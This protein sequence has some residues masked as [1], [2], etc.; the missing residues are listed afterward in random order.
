MIKIEVKSQVLDYIKR[1]WKELLI[2]ALLSFFY[3]KGK[4]DYASLYDLHLETTQTY[5]KRIEDLNK[6]HKERIKEKDEAIEQYIQRVEDLRNDYDTQ[7]EEIKTDRKE[8]QEEIEQILL[9]KPEELI[10][11][12]ETRFGF[13]YV[14]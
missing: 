8:R 10:T 6:A 13:K 7:K 3:I 5:E 11:N 12:I 4:M 14:E 9:E 2:V 1:N